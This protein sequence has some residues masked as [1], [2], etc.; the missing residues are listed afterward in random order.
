MKTK[1]YTG[2]CLLEVGLSAFLVTSSLSLSFKLL[3]R[4]DRDL[5][6]GCRNFARSRALLIT[7]VNVGDYIDRSE[8]LC[9]GFSKSVV[10][11]SAG[12]E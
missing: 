5:Q 8:R 1:T 3:V 11:D 10:E 12:L 7:K 6:R 4:E 9:R 2:Q